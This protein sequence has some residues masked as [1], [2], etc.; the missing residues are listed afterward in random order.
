MVYSSLSPSLKL[1]LPP[2]CRL[3]LLD[4]GR[5]RV[6]QWEALGALQHLMRLRN[7]NLQGNKVCSE[8]G[9]TAKVNSWNL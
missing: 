7:L 5:N 8:E 4:V 9:Y 6:Y 2:P 1:S 3:Q